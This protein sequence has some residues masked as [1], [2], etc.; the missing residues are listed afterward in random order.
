MEVEYVPIDATR[1]VN[2]GYDAVMLD[3]PEQSTCKAL[4]PQVD[5][6]G[7]VQYRWSAVSEV[8]GDA[9]IRV[10]LMQVSGDANVPHA[11][12]YTLLRWALVN[13]PGDC[14]TIRRM[15]ILIDP[16]GTGSNFR[17]G[18]CADYDK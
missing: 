1:L 5:S 15:R 4:T 8:Q 17:V 9:V 7:G 11:A 3:I 2:D 10:P 16:E 6:E 12:T 13:L 14:N 18:L